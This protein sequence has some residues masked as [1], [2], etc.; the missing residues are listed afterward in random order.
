MDPGLSVEG[1]ELVHSCQELSNL[2][3]RLGHSIN[4]KGLERSFDIQRAMNQHPVTD[5]T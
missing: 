5:D 3:R 2:L 1:M 4:R